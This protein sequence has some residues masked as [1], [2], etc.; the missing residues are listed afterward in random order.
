M[1]KWVNGILEGWEEIEA[2]KP[3]IPTFPYSNDPKQKKT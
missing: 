3:M 1:E 2:L